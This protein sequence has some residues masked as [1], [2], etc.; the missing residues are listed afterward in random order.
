V[1]K[2]K[3]LFLVA[4][5][6]IAVAVIASS[7]APAAPAA[8]P[9]APAA[10]PAAPAATP[11]APAATPAAPAAAPA[12]THSW[13]D[14][15]TYTNDAVGFTIQY[16]AKWKQEAPD[17]ADTVTVFQ[18]AQDPSNNVGDR[19]YVAVIPAASDL[20]TVAKG[21]LD[22]SPAFIKYKVT[23][24]VDSAKAFTLTSGSVTAAEEQICS[25]KIVIYNFYFY[26]ISATKGDKTVNVMGGT[27]GGG[28]AKKQL[29]E[30]CQ[31][32]SFK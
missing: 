1:F 18:G 3:A 5:L 16:P 22:S 12:G 10:T 17:P 14:S 8:T 30:I 28:T 9:A 29:M 19:I 20:S 6:V 27:I 24:K 21:L 7:C 15:A 23:S 31:T 32:L 11:A 4:I 13:G 25:A 26:A 2:N